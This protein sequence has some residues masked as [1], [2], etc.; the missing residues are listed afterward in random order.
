MAENRQSTQSSNIT[1]G[2]LE[3]SGSE[4]LEQSEIEISDFLKMDEW[5]GQ[6]ELASIV[7][8]HAKNPSC[9]ASQAHGHV[10]ASSSHEGDTSR[11]SSSGAQETRQ[12]TERVAFKTKSE[13]EKLDDGYK[14][15]KYGKK[16]VKNNPNPRNYYKCS[17]DGCPVKKRVERDGDDPS[18]VITVYEGI[19]NHPSPN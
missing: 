13:D 10:S 11:D 12:A 3:S 5:P 4:S 18:Y 16:T 17:I 6:E 2:S 14:W 8:G 1:F 9:Q 15:R 7:F 19:H